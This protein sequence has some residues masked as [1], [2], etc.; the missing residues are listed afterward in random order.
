MRLGIVGSSYSVGRHVNGDSVAMPFEDHIKKHIPN[1]YIHNSAAA[2]K[3][4]EL[5]LDKVVY[6]KREH[7]IDTLLLELVNNRRMLNILIDNEET[8]EITK[9]DDI[10]S[11]TNK[12]YNNS[13]S[14]YAY[15]RYIHQQIDHAPIVPS[16]FKNWKMVQE[17]LASGNNMNHMWA[18]ID[19]YQVINLCEML[20]IRVVCW[21]NRWRF[22][23]LP[24]FQSLVNNVDYVQFPNHSCASDY[25]FDKYGKEN[26][27]FDE[28]HF[29]DQINEEMVRDFICPVLKN[30][31]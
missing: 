13:A 16:E 31:T 3:G 10:R 25:Y 15:Q 6:L 17:V 28:S 24:S 12:V 29:T 22:P 30:E 26:V 7:D 11:L 4:T 23:E 2:S 21:N 20:N 27:L 14:I 18:M 1:I 8:E 5:Y 9:T 19:C